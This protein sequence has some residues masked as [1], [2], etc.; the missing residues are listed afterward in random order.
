MWSRQGTVGKAMV[1]TKM[2]TSLV[3]LWGKRNVN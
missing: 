2:G 3:R 1:H